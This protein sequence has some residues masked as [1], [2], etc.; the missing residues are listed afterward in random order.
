MRAALQGPGGRITL[1]ANQLTIGRTADNQLVVSDPKASSHHAIISQSP[2]GYSITDL[3]STNGTYVNEQRLEP[4]VPRMLYPGERIR[5]GDTNYGYEDADAALPPTVSAN[6]P[7]YTAYGGAQSGAY[8]PVQPSYAPFNSGQ[9]NPNQG[10]YMAPPPPAYG[11]PAQQSFTPVNFGPP[12]YGAPAQQAFPPMTPG[13]PAYAAPTEQAFPP[14]TPGQPAYGPPQ[15]QQGF[16]SA[17]PAYMP[18]PQIPSYGPPPS[19]QRS[20]GGLKIGLIILVV[21]LVLALGGG[22]VAY[23][24]YANRPQ[25]TISVSSTYKVGTTPA[26]STSTALHITGQKFSK[27]SAITFL[28]DGATAP[29]TQNVQSDASGNVSADLTV[30]DGWAVGTH[31]LTARDASNYTTADATAIEI[32]PQGQAK[33]PGPNGAPSDDAS[34]T[35]SVSVQRQNTSTGATLKPFTE[36]LTVTGK[37]DGGTVCQSLDDSQP[38]T[39]TGTTTDGAATYSDTSTATCSGTYK[40]G[41]ITFTETV[42]SDKITYSDIGA[43]TFQTPYVSQ[44]I[45]GTFSSATSISN[46]TYSA[47]SAHM[48]CADGKSY[49][50]DPEKGTWNGSATITGNTSA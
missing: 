49:H 16:A 27:S 25:P 11:A 36:T 48:A 1:G 4:N 32:V 41:K 14:M 24:I 8:P 40:G 42:T 39:T 10:G 12:A 23:Y 7:G 21:V 29:G 43:C 20:S 50:F 47:D 2:Q 38:H 5:I 34:F 6:P 30:T 13:Q 9:S 19:T 15:G 37:P 3:G 31:K 35:I 45:S 46:G 22:G 17:Q 28:L 26:G 33:T 18:P 44:Q